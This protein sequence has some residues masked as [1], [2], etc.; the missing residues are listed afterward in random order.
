MTEETKP[1]P[2][3]LKCCPF[4]GSGAEY[5]KLGDF[6]LVECGG[7]CDIN[8]VAYGDS[9]EQASKLWENRA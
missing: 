9:Y 3:D 2:D 5:G 1:D 7:R 6:F 4:C 8:P